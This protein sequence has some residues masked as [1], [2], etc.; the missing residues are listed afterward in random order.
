MVG[1]IDKY[2]FS[3]WGEK[4]KEKKKK[5]QVKWREKY[6]CMNSWVGWVEH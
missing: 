4:V 5:K 2:F 1:K 6:V 3:S